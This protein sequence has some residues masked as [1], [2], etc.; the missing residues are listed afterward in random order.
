M[1]SVGKD[2][3]DA[4]SQMSRTKGGSGYNI[5]PQIIPERGNLSK[6][7]VEVGQNKDT[8]RVFKHCETGSKFAN[9]SEGIG[10]EPAL[11]ISTA[12]LSE[13]ACR[14]ARHDAR[15]DERKA[16]GVNELV[17]A[18]AGAIAEVGVASRA[19]DV[20]V[21]LIFRFAVIHTAA[22]LGYIAE[23]GNVR[24]MRREHERGVRVNFTERDGAK[25]GSFKA[26]GEAANA[27]EQIQVGEFIHRRGVRWR[28]A[29]CS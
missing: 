16:V 4:L 19:V 23:V 8:W 26:Q 11:V 5:P 12:H 22:Q 18:D 10:P 24:P 3:D 14:L 9:H 2:K 25:P 17:G 21:L 1:S 28:E 7:S 13:R 20:P 6:D 29:I 15:N 27:A